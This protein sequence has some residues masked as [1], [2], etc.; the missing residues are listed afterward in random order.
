M[1]VFVSEVEMSDIKIKVKTVS[2][3]NKTFILQGNGGHG[4]YFIGQYPELR[5]LKRANRDF[6][7]ANPKYSFRMID[8]T[9]TDKIIE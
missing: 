8:R 4:W 2:L 1:N 6:V 3:T 9:T 7:K 5:N